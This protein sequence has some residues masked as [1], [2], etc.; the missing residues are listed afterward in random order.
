V[1]GRGAGKERE[2]RV[3]KMF[4]NTWKMFYYY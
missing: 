2:G 1:K 3:A 4:E